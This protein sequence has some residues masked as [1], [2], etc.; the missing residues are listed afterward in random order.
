MD[1]FSKSPSGSSRM[2]EIF[3]DRKSMEET[4]TLPKSLVHELVHEVRNPLSMIKGTIQL[5]KLKQKEID[6]T[7]LD[8][9]VAEVDR[10]NRTLEEFVT[11]AKSQKAREQ[12]QL[13]L[14]LTEVVK[15]LSSDSEMGDIELQLNC[16]PQDVWVNGHAEQL[17]QLLFHISRN[18]R[19]AME[20]VGQLTFR[21]KLISG[22]VA[23]IQIA[24]TG[25]GIDP[26]ILDQVFEP[27]FTTK[28]GGSGL[29]L[30]VCRRIVQDHQGEIFVENNKEKGCTLY[31]NLPVVEVASQKIVLNG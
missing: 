26:A 15:F 6:S 12:F 4:L 29:G 28:P 27:C 24:D 30:A 18:A 8:R 31:I 10:I 14:L 17:K 13:N 23:Q 3:Y 16:C 1:C 20:G 5:V 9:I 11:L 2:S 7:Y 22:Q 25:T 21:L 19:E